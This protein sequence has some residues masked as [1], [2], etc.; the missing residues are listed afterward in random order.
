MGSDLVCASVLHSHCIGIRDLVDNPILIDVLDSGRRVRRLDRTR[1]HLSIEH[2]HAMLDFLIIER[3]IILSYF[4][5]D[6]VECSSHVHQVDTD[7]ESPK[8]RHKQVQ[9]ECTFT[10]VDIIHS[11]LNHRP[12]IKY[13][14]APASGSFHC[15]LE[16]SQFIGRDL[17]ILPELHDRIVHEN[18][19]R[20]QTVEQDG[21]WVSTITFL[22]RLDHR[23]PYTRLLQRPRCLTP[24][25]MTNHS[26][27][28]RPLFA[29]V[30]RSS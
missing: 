16:A 24:V 29:L 19:T 14:F 2:L 18:V 11:G 23:D 6:P 12:R 3:A 10:T 1:F 25:H 8:C 28:H 30:P 17:A 7:S 9:D 27:A 13:E 15:V 26:A 22:D 21:G 5:H 4:L 20:M